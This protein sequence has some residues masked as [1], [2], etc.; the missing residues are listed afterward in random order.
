MSGPGRTLAGVHTIQLARAQW[1]MIDDHYR[2]RFL[3]VEEP[4]VLKETRETHIK[5][6]VRWW[7]IDPKMR[8]VR[9]VC[10]GLVAAE[11][12]CREAITQETAKKAEL[13]A[14]LDIRKQARP[15]T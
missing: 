3:I 4:V 11:T 14:Q 5:H 8:E 10:D 13:S 1:L 6:V 9:A 7:N 2:P 15:E 12:W